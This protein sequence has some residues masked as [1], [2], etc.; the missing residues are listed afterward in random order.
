MTLAL[1]S[2]SYPVT[3]A[4]AVV[5]VTVAFVDHVTNL[6]NSHHYT[7]SPQYNSYQ[8][9]IPRVLHRMDMVWHLNNW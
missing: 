3:A 4:V 2:H 6:N 5:A 8:K 1:H 7:V 9:D